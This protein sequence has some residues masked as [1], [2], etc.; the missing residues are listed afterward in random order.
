MSQ[1]PIDLCQHMF[2]Y[3][4]DV[5]RQQAIVWANVDSDIWRHMA[6]LGHNE[7]NHGCLYKIW[8]LLKYN[9]NWILLLCKSSA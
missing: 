2:R 6:P 8:Q 4:L 3:C 9:L 1:S 7:L 5:V